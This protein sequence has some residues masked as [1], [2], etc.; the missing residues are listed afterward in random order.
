MSNILFILN[1]VL[2]IWMKGSNYGTSAKLLAAALTRNNCANKGKSGCTQY[3]SAKVANPAE[4]S[5]RF[6]CRKAG[7]P[8]RIK[9]PF[10]FSLF[11]TAC[12]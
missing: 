8:R 11:Q 7:V 2:R 5:A 1:D 10:R 12:F 3:I 6:V 9:A 4:N